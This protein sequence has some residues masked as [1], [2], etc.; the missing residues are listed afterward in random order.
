MCVCVC[1][2]VV[3]AD[4]PVRVEHW[5]ELEDKYVSES[6]GARVVSPQDEVEET[7]EHEG[8]GRLARVHTAAQE[9]GRAH[10]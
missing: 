5:N 2:P 4:H 8:R 9:I 10:V 3:A 7:V 6:V 1:V